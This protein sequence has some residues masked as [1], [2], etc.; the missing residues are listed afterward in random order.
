MGVHASHADMLLESLPQY[1]IAAEEAINTVLEGVGPLGYPAAVLL[2]CVIDAMG[3]YLRGKPEG[4]VT[5]DGISREIKSDSDHYLVLNSSYFGLN[6][7]GTTFT[8]LNDQC[9]NPLVH[10]AVLGWDVRL[11]QQGFLDRG[12]VYRADDGM[13]EIDLMLLHEA[14]K[15]ASGKFME[16]VERHVADSRAIRN[17]EKKSKLRPDSAGAR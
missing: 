9:R 5:V 2:L 3:S 10:N 11:V 17:L 15:R 4:I 16:D 14:C 6:L 1:V 13:L 8:D 7:S 12:P